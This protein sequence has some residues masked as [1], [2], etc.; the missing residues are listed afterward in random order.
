MINSS[1]KSQRKKLV[2]VISIIFIVSLFIYFYRSSTPIQII[3]G[4]IQNIFSKPKSTVYSIGKNGKL[5]SDYQ[6]K[7]RDLEKRTVD[8]ELL[9]QDNIALKSQFLASGET[10]VNLTTARILGFQG[11]NRNPRE[12]II[13]VGKKD[14]IQEG[15]SVVFQKYFIGKVVTVSQN[16]SVVITPFNP[17]FQVLS[18]LPETNANGILVGQEDFMLLTGVIITDN[19]KKGGIIVTKG[20][21]NRLGIGVVPDMILGKIDSISKNE[22][23]P[24]QSAQIKPLLDFS[25]LT[26]VFV[27]SQM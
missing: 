3:Q 18:K 12:L 27:I 4:S 20:E 19:L 7:L 25:K 14:K 16:Y 21:V 6:K 17:K 1:P 8:Y 11:S 9:K 23:A 13:N 24:F 26:N 5:D 15:M 22:N 10:S 2:F